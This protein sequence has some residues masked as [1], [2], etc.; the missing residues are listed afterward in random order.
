MRKRSS[1]YWPKPIFYRKCVCIKIFICNDTQFAGWSEIKH[2]RS[3]TQPAFRKQVIEWQLYTQ[4]AQYPL[5]EQ[6]NSGQIQ[7]NTE[8][9][10][11]IAPFCP[12]IT[13]IHKCKWE[14]FCQGISCANT[15]AYRIMESAFG[16]NSAR[17]DMNRRKTHHP[18]NNLILH[19]LSSVYLLY[20]NLKSS[21]W[22]SGSRHHWDKPLLIKLALPGTCLTFSLKW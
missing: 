8:N 6:I 19:S 22:Y 9:F 7:W 2:K 18:Q 10:D 11:E 16:P 15:R 5:N 21:F 4:K 12:S 13:Q 17:I 20:A 14:A 3:Y 1:V